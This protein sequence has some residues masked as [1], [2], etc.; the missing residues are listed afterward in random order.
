M[1]CK[2][3]NQSEMVG[4]LYIVFE[5][6]KA[7]NSK[8]LPPQEMKINDNWLEVTNSIKINKFDSKTMVPGSY[9]MIKRRGC[10]NKIIGSN[11]YSREKIVEMD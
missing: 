2:T 5:L 4:T 1:H 6:E 8:I 3:Y 9:V 7:S 11:D 10:S